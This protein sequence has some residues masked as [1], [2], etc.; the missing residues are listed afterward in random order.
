MIDYQLFNTLTDRVRP[1][2]IHGDYHFHLFCR[3][4]SMS[5]VY[6]GKPFTVQAGDLLVWQR[7]KAYSEVKYSWNFDADYLM[8]SNP[9]L[10]LLEPEKSWAAIGY[11]HIKNTPVFHLDPDDRM[12]IEADLKQF[13]QRSGPS[14]AVYGKDIVDQMMKVLVYDLWSIYSREIVKSEIDDAKIVHFLR[15]M[16]M[17][18]YNCPEQR[19]VSWYARNLGITPKYL[20]EISQSVTKRPASDWIDSFTA[21]GLRKLLSEQRLTISGIIDLLHFS[22]HPVFTR[23]FK[24]IM[25]TTPSEYLQEH[26]PEGLLADSV[27]PPVS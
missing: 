6:R 26:Q 11:M 8:I 24:R 10:N 27:S 20:T 14:K 18:Q 19:E 21:I 4:G 15:F 23:Y 16:M 13:R 1:E 25:K 9:F 12:T 5:F 7:T 2:T 22:S 17:A 3:S